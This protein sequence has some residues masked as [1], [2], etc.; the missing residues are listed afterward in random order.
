MRRARAGVVPDR[1]AV[2]RQHRRAARP[3]ALDP[4]AVGA[5]ALGLEDPAHDDDAAGRIH[6]EGR[7]VQQPGLADAR[8]THEEQESSAAV[9]ECRRRTPR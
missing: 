8:L 2:A 3:A 4:H 5:T 6:V 1:C 9:R 7:L